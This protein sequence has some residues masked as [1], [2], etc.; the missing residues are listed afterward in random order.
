MSDSI[1]QLSAAAPP[2]LPGPAGPSRPPA[3]RRRRVLWLTAGALAVGSTGFMAI[4]ATSASFTSQA[5]VTGYSVATATVEIQAGTAATST[6]ITAA[7]LLPGDV[8]STVVD[9]KNTGT[10]GVYYA[11]RL[12]LVTGGDATLQD[13]LQVTVSVGT[14]SETKSLTAW[15]AGALQIGPALAASQADEVTVTVQLPA[16]AD[17]T[18]QGTG[19]AFSVLID[20]IQERNTPQPTAGWLAD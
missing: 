20:A 12:P 13:A 2:A 9:V 4:S 19:A 18:V 5:T 8:A 15:Q 3:I 16:T 11:V 7:D 1:A 14:A 17:N 10:Q 6:P